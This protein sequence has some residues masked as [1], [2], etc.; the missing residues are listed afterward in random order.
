MERLKRAKKIKKMNKYIELQKLHYLLIVIRAF[1]VL[2]N[3]RYTMEKNIFELH[4]LKANQELNEGLVFFKESKKLKKLA[5]QIDNRIEKAGDDKEKKQLKDYVNII[6]DFAEKFE[7]IEKLYK[8]DKKRAKELHKELK[9]NAKKLV[10]EA[11]KDMIKLFVKIGVGLALFA[12]IAAIFTGQWYLGAMVGQQAAGM[13]GGNEAARQR[14]V[15]KAIE[16][17]KSTGDA[18][19]VDKIYRS[20]KGLS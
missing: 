19:K 2:F 4:I 13:G 12:S 6:L 10:K 3:Q 7:K 17:I 14:S 8:Q 15:Q 20:I 11:D 18:N 5:K 16:G 1:K 9:E